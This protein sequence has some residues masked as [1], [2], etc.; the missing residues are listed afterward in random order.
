MATEVIMPKFGMAQ[1][2][3]QVIQWFIEEGK[4]VEEGE[5]LL[6][7]MTDKVSM[8]V[9]A[10]ASGI[11]QAVSAHPDDI[12]P[13][14][15]VIAYIVAEGE[16]WTPP[17][18]PVEPVKEVEAPMPVAAA[19]IPEQPISVI[20]TPVAQRLA[21]ERGVDLRMI[22][23]SGPHGR[24]TR[25]DV[26]TQLTKKLDRDEAPTPAPT[27]DKVRATPAA[28]RLARELGV[29]LQSILGSGPRG[30]VQAADVKSFLTRPAVEVFAPRREEQIVPLTGMRRII[31]ERMSQSFQSAP[32][33]SF[34][35]HADVTQAE[36]LRSKANQRLSKRGGPK[37]SLTAILVRVVAWALTE[38]P[39]MNASLQEDGI[40]LLPNV[41]IGV[42]T[43]L[44]EGLIV[45]VV[46]DAD[47]KGLAQITEELNDLTNRA[48]E[49]ELVPDEV[50]GGSFTI[51]NLGMF[52]I[53]DFT[54]ILNPPETGILAVGTIVRQPIAL[55]SDE[56][57][58]RPRI[59]LTLSADHRVVDGVVGARFLAD[60][61]AAIEEPHMLLL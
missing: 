1:E 15:R 7:V 46:R 57:V 30:R 44:E 24:I 40:H 12:V 55:E 36:A 48:R 25:Q 2:E 19:P 20:A 28:R 27:P 49:G 50:I 14:A 32:H 43:A 53:E 33:I 45:P 39:W 6:E 26:E 37:V 3:G 61:K 56:I 4:A 34:T 38:H 8:E 17:E 23:G 58:I 21:A 11:L 5:P 54:A 13:V 52:G 10:P 41:H 31:A 51:S 47:R 9:E 42:A 16:E 22:D 60:V 29:R 59:S 18:E 35:L